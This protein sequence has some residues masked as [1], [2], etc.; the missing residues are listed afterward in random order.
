[1]SHSSLSPGFLHAKSRANKSTKHREGQEFQQKIAALTEVWAG[2]E[3]LST[4]FSLESPPFICW[5]LPG[6]EEAVQYKGAFGDHQRKTRQAKKTHSSVG[7]NQEPLTEN[8]PGCFPCRQQFGFY[9][10]FQ[11]HS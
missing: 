3:E 11:I 1:M 4:V 8:T 7:I 9:F 10:L 6:Q 5:V 2:Q